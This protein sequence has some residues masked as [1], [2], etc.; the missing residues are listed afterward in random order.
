L[1]VKV[2][3]PTAQISPNS[4]YLCLLTSLSAHAFSSMYYSCLLHK[5]IFTWNIFPL[6]LYLPCPSLLLRSTIVFLKCS[7][8]K[9]FLVSIFS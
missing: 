3:P 7:I 8:P 1:S 4:R 5:D 2:L 6:Y 9:Q